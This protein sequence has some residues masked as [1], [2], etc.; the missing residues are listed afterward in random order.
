MPD[1]PHAQILLPVPGRSRDKPRSYRYR[2]NLLFRSREPSQ[3]L[4]PHKVK[5]CQAQPCYGFG[6]HSK[7]AAYPQIA[8]RRVSQLRSRVEEPVPLPRNH[9]LFNRTASLS[10]PT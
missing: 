6:E 1:T 5:S 10:P 7:R 2:V 3:I 9:R 4:I 8:I